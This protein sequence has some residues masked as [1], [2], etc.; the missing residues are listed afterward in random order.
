[1]MMTNRVHF[2]MLTVQRD[3]EGGINFTLRKVKSISREICDSNVKLFRM[4]HGPLILLFLRS[5]CVDVEI[6]TVVQ[7]YQRIM[8]I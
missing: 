1:M 7:L 6:N 8:R 5:A 3:I 2:S 4:G